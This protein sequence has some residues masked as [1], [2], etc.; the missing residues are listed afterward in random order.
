MSEPEHD[1]P[2]GIGATKSFVGGSSG[3]T[4]TL[5]RRDQDLLEI[6]SE[7]APDDLKLVV[8]EGNLYHLGG[9]DEAGEPVLSTWDELLDAL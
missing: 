1:A 8:M 6:R 7:S 5:F 9:D 4:L 2:P 3:D